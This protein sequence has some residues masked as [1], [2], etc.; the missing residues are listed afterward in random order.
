MGVLPDQVS[1]VHSVCRQSL[2][3][4]MGVL[5]DQVGQRGRQHLLRGGRRAP[6]AGAGQDALGLG[7]GAP[8]QGVARAARDAN[9][10]GHAPAAHVHARP[11]AHVGLHPCA[12][13]H[14]RARRV[15]LARSRHPTGASLLIPL[16]SPPLACR[17]PKTAWLVVLLCW[18]ERVAPSLH[19]LA[20]RTALGQHAAHPGQGAC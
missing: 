4:D 2:C 17:L 7:G 10:A 11:R 15:L 12:V 18:C 13:G 5:P 9:A 16:T 19:F 6:G 8:E 14:R 1:P 3:D 20:R